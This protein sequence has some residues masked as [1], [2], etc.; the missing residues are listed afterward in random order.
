MYE[1]TIAKQYLK[2]YFKWIWKQFTC[3]LLSKT[4]YKYTIFIVCNKNSFVFNY[5]MLLMIHCF[6][7]H[8]VMD[9][10]NDYSCGILLNDSLNVSE[11]VYTQYPKVVFA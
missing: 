4:Y 2:I 1:L 7:I 11:A 3:I 8:T 9:H 6:R 5:S 10:Q